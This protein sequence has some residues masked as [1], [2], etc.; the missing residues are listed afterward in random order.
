LNFW[1]NEK[2]YLIWNKPKQINTS[3]LLIDFEWRS[4][5]N[6]EIF[7]EF[8]KVWYE[9]SLEFHYDLS[10]SQY[11]INEENWACLYKTKYFTFAKYCD[12]VDV[13]SFPELEETLRG[14]KLK[15]EWYPEMMGMFEQ[16]YFIIK[17]LVLSFE[18]YDRMPVDNEFSDSLKGSLECIEI[19]IDLGNKSITNETSSKIIEFI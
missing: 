3:N 19:K 17:H 16:W 4:N 18:E 15:V 12:I 5:K 8:Y 13:Y 10:C 7:H 11:I 2:Y 9:K 1:N 14:E 6:K